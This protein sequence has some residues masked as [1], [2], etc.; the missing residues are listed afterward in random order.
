M[1]FGEGGFKCAH[2]YIWVCTI[3]ARANRYA[4]LD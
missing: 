3:Y 1:P 4:Q 2:N